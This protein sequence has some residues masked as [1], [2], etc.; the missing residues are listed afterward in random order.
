MSFKEFLAINREIGIFYSLHLESHFLTWAVSGQ[1]EVYEV[2]A[3]RKSRVSIVKS[4]WC[5]AQGVL[6][7]VGFCLYP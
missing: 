6:P 5:Q 2:R 1:V 3:G 7:A 4:T